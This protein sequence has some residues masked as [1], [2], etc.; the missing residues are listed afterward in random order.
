MNECT[1]IG[2]DVHKD[3]LTRGVEGQDREGNL[4][5]RSRQGSILIART[6]VSLRWARAPGGS[7]IGV[8]MVLTMIVQSAYVNDGRKLT[9]S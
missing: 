4:V 2:L 8:L 5:L 1:H 9:S 7:A 3:A 6:R